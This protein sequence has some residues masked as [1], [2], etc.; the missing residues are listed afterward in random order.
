MNYTDINRVKSVADI[1]HSLRT[2]NLIQEPICPMWNPE[3]KTLSFSISVLH[4]SSHG[5]ELS[6][7]MFKVIDPNIQVKVRCMHLDIV[8]HI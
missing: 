1:I 7:E 4:S 5:V 2:L 6:T 8:V 3:E